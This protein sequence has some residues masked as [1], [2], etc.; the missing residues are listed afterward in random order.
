MD[1][2]WKPIK[3][4]EGYY[5]VSNLGRIKALE[6]VVENNGGM[7]KKHERILKAGKENRSNGIYYSVSLCKNKK[8]YRK[9]VHRI[10]AETF[11]PNP[12]NKPIVDHIDTN[13]SNNTVTN[14]RW[15][16]VK[17]NALNPLTRIHNSNSKMGHKPYLYKHTEESKKKMSMAKKGRPLTVEHRNKLSESHKNS[18]SARMKS[19]ENLKKAHELR[20]GSKHSEETKQK[21]K[22]KSLGRYKGKHWKVIDG[23]RIWLD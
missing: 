20:I 19:L 10:V 3:D 2:V 8:V 4:F 23:K 21:I 1:E 9:L 11:I 17:E 13:P 14:L 12:E 7:Q 18:V 22:E 5:E 15:V 6:R 16:T